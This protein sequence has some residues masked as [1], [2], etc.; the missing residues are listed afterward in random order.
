MIISIQYLQLPPVMDLLFPTCLKEFFWTL[1]FLNFQGE[2][3]YNALSIASTQGAL[4]EKFELHGYK[5]SEYLFNVLDIAVLVGFFI[6]LIPIFLLA[7]V[8]TK[9]VPFMQ[10]LST[11]YVTNTLQDII[12]LVYF[13][14]ALATLMYWDQQNIDNWLQF[15]SAVL[16]IVL[17]FV[18]FLGWPFITILMIVKKNCLFWKLDR[19]KRKK[20]EEKKAK[21]D[22]FEKAEAHVEENEKKD[23]GVDN[24]L[25]F[26]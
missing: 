4:N 18:I 22:L 26:L 10:Q 9:D 23:P 7:K 25:T 5:T 21:T 16:N 20:A 8:F 19:E 1:R 13:K 11:R 15:W 6:L 17:T 2:F 3:I 14:N 24:Y 12:I